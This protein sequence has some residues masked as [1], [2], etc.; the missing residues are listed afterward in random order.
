MKRAL[1]LSTLF[2]ILILPKSNAQHFI[3]VT[4]FGVTQSWGMPYE[5]VHFIEHD[6]WGYNVVHT[7]RINQN[8]KLFFDIV[9]QRGDV[10]VTVSVGR[11]GRIYNRVVTYDYP[12][13][14]HV[15][16]NSC[17]YH[18][19]FYQRNVVVCNS[20]HHHGHNHVTYVRHTNH[21]NHPGNGHAYGKY[22]SNGNDHHDHKK[23][24][25]DNNSYKSRANSREYQSRSTSKV[26]T[27]KNEPY[28]GR[29]SSSSRSGN[30]SVSSRRSSSDSQSNGRSSGSYKS[31]SGSSSTSTRTR[32]N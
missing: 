20:H 30:A 16:G 5:V 2:A 28:S 17:G 24:Y 21:Y 6:Y 11:F 15:C 3:F 22:K 1:L 32:S 18:S 26:Y 9:L 23:N 31:R 13:Y 7:R 29:S 19:N 27:A 14:N 8:G 12:F 25:R 10:F 4:S